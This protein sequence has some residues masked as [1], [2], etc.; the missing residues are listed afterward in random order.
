L[1]C[2]RS[3]LDTQG[4]I[5]YTFVLEKGLLITI[6][7]LA[8]T[9]LP[10]LFF[11]HHERFQCNG[12]RECM[13]LS[14]KGFSTAA[15]ART[16]VF[17]MPEQL[18]RL[19][20]RH[21]QGALVRSWAS[22]AMWLVAALAFFTGY[23]K[24]ANILGIS[25]CVAFEIL[26]N[27]PTLAVLRAIRKRRSYELFSVFINF[28]DVIAYTGIIYFAG[29]FNYL[30]LS[31]MLANLVTYVGVLGPSRLPFIMA[32]FSTLTV[33]I[34]V[35]LVHYGIIP[36]IDSEG[37]A[38]PSLGKQLMFL[39]SIAGLIFVQAFIASYSSSLLR[40]QH[41]KLQKQNV[42]LEE[43]HQR[44][45]RAQEEL[46][47]SHKELEN[48]VHERTAELRKTVNDLETA[49]RAKSDFLANMSHELRTPLNHI[50]GFTDLILG[51]NFGELTE[52]QEEYLND[53]L[54]SSRHLLSLINDI[55][56]LSKVEAGKM[57]MN[58]EDVSLRTLIE[59]GLAMV[60][61]K[62]LKQ[63][64]RV[65]VKMS[66]ALQTIRAD[67]RKLKQIMYN[68]LSNAV[69]FTPE[70]GAIEVSAD[71]VSSFEYPISGKS[72]NWE[73]KAETGDF[74]QISVRDTGIGI[75]WENLERIFD[76]FEQVETS[77]SRHYQG[78]GLGLS[79][80]QSL[81]ELHG[82]RIW[83]ESEGEGKGS[84]FSFVIPA[85]GVGQRMGSEERAP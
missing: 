12:A 3:I 73:W 79:L 6:T 60:K 82:G 72:E 18:E 67:E 13:E 58:L 9:S 76:P 31:L 19:N 4:E 56:D 63:D 54:D 22:V 47:R 44:L 38:L 64:I 70:G 48:R 29:G 35:F 7:C 41:V 15:S 55:L 62:A 24:P 27:P 75:S 69:K 83:A 85:D 81:V 66:E 74:I 16:P 34:M 53:V 52:L 80:T 8:Q 42:Q 40:K 33:T 65:T 2:A 26:I 57:E 39:L 46:L 17:L 71:R 23:Q 37:I 77:R 30:C 36:N 11:F 10:P 32:S 49:N 21:A 78:T 45:R 68:L 1:K 61:E 25:A 50:M 43:S 84:R 59:S 51:K 14:G 5:A 20:K 28:L